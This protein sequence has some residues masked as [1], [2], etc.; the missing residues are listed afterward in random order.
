MRKY[1]LAVILII[2]LLTIAST[3]VVFAKHKEPHKYQVSAFDIKEIQAGKRKALD[4][5]KRPVEARIIFHHKPG[6]N[7]GPGGGGGGNDTTSN[8]FAFIS[9]GAEWK[10]TEP[11]VLDPNNDAG[12]SSAF[13]TTTTATS[14]ETWDT[15]VA[16]DIFGT[17]NT[18]ATVDGIDTVSPDGK[19]EVLFGAID[20]PGTIGL[21]IIWGIFRGPPSQREIV[22]YDTIFDDEDFLWGD[23][24]LNI[25]F[26]DYQAVATHE[27]GHSAGLAHPSDSCTEETMYRFISA[28]ET[29]Q[30]DLNAGDITGI[31][32]L[33]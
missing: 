21:T 3:A 6:H 28:G 17:R 2:S 26:T 24:T 15:E 23:A 16:F 22:E 20:S 12:L 19:N 18:T 32:E 29:K 14:F 30:R 31:N 4:I 25:N 13:I 7:K 10:T 5:D 11:Y 8:C 27:F 1:T 9:K 33:Y